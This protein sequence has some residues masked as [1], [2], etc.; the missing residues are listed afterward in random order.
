MV[1]SF[2]PRD[3]RSHVADPTTTNKPV[4]FKKTVAI[5]RTHY[6]VYSK[7]KGYLCSCPN[8]DAANDALQALYYENEKSSRRVRTEGKKSKRF[9]CYVLARTGIQ[10]RMIELQFAQEE[11]DATETYE[12]IALAAGGS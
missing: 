5:E 2:H 12:D 10:S 9:D 11:E 8:E 7:S 4:K 1:K 3:P 6:D